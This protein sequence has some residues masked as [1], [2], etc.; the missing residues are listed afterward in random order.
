M[1]DDEALQKMFRGYAPIVSAQLSI[2]EEAEEEAVIL[3]R[4]KEIHEEW[5]TNGAMYLGRV[6]ERT[7]E[8]HG[9][10]VLL[11]AIQ[12]HKT[13]ICGKTGSGKSYTMG[14][15]AEELAQLNIGIGVVLVDPMGVFWSMKFP[16]KR[17]VASPPISDWGLQPKGFRNVKVFVPVGVYSTIP[18]GTRDAAFAIRPNE[19]SPEDWCNTFGLDMY[20]SPQGALLI[21]I[22]KAI[23]I[24]YVAEGQGKRESV[25]PQDNYTIDDMKHCLEHNVEFPGKYRSSSIRALVMHLEAARNWGIFSTT[26]TP[27]QSLS[28]PNRVGVVDVSF[29]PDYSRALVVGILA[30]KILEERTKIARHFKAE[31]LG[32]AD[33]RQTNVDKIPV[34]WLMVDEAHVLVPSR[35]KT[36][37]SEALVEY[38]KRGR[39][40]GCAL[41][42]CT[43]QPHATDDRILSQVDVLVCHNLSFNDDISAY[44]AR[45]PSFLPSE[46]SDQSFVRRLPVGAAVIA[47]QS[48]T[49]ERAFVMQVRPRVSEHAGRIIRPKVHGP[50]EVLS[51]DEVNLEEE[52]AE[53]V[54]QPINVPRVPSL[55]IRNSLAADYLNRVIKYRFSEY[56]Q[57]IGEKRFTQNFTFLLPEVEHE[58]LS[59][60]LERLA[61]IS[62]TI[63]EIKDIDG[64]PVVLLHNEKAKLVLATCLTENATVVTFSS[65]SLEEHSLGEQAELVSRVLRQQIP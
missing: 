13:F 7:G 38:A 2:L 5:G 47:D 15:I 12:P 45:A 3:G 36:A 53:V 44:R 31:E 57:P 55:L 60:L 51:E 59:I 18:E 16:N 1:V 9:C 64:M 43:Q 27:I 37:A 22:I 62:Y 49:T 61:R 39:M 30:R 20:K 4:T 50:K 63:D 29:L 52:R 42:L 58:I 35:G 11:D 25:P 6:C 40:P 28:A 17:G 41:V 10:R 65:S 8:L 21:D 26:A 46:L 24:G 54:P 14:V 56:L 34:T 32:E 19:L 23:N 33:P 48:M